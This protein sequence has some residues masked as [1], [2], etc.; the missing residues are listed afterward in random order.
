METRTLHF[1]VFSESLNE[2]TWRSTSSSGPDDGLHLTVCG[3]P[4]DV[5]DE[6]VSRWLN[7]TTLL[8]PSS[9]AG[10]PLH[11]DEL[12]RGR[13]VNLYRGSGS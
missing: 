2:A 6:S 5:R 1:V 11:F 3:V 10:R 7:E 13:V 4:G 9:G 8:L 12:G